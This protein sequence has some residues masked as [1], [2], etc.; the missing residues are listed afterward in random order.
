MQNSLQNK[1]TKYNTMALEQNKHNT[2]ALEQ[3]GQMQYYSF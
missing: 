1:T 3:N 2:K